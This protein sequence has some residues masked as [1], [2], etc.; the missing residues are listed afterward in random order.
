[1]DSNKTIIF[2]QELKKQDFE[3]DIFDDSIRHDDT[4]CVGSDGESCQGAKPI[5]GSVCN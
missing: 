1:V 2:A 3:K 4:L 5:E